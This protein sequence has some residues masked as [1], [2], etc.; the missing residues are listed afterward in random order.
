MI[1]G[2]S[3]LHFKDYLKVGIPMCIMSLILCVLLIPIF[4]P[5]VE[6]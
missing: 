5:F 4:W 6:N 2:P 3:G 1:L